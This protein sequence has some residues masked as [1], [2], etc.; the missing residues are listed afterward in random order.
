MA[1]LEIRHCSWPPPDE[2]N[3]LWNVDF[4][5]DAGDVAIITSDTNEDARLFLRA[6]A[7]LEKPVTGEFLFKGEALS[8][9][10]YRHLLA[11]KRKVGYIA[12]DAYL[13]SNR[14]LGEN[15]VLAQH[16]LD[17]TS[18]ASLEP[19]RFGGRHLEE[20]RPKLA[21]RPAKAFR[22]D[23]RL[24]VIVRELSKNPEMILVERPDHDLDQTSY[25]EFVQTLSEIAAHKV[26]MV[27]YS[28]DQNLIQSV[29]NRRVC[30]Q[31]G[32]VSVCPYVKD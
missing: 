6:L 31:K 2:G 23:I 12:L 11:Y 28:F 19:G 29:A 24:A 13:L 27:F 21:L 3:G 4:T 14:T 30:I 18:S 9:A 7:S 15:L 10:D 20:I 8:F 17:D 26:P 1:F 32:A 5:L 16:F 22:E 25:A